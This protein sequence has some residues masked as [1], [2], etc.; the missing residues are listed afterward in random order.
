MSFKTDEENSGPQPFIR[1]EAQSKRQSTQVRAAGSGGLGCAL[2]GVV[3]VIVAVLIGVALFLPPFSLGARLFGTPYVQLNQQT[4]SAAQ[5]GL[6][7]AVDPAN[8]GSGF[9]VRLKTIKPEVFNGQAA[10][11]AEES[12]WL[13]AARASLPPTLTLLSP[14]Y[15]IDS[16]GTAS[17]VSLTVTA[18][19][20]AD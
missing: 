5:N 17:T 15:Q 8:V 13:K 3:I 9:G 20:G 7:V 19:Q 1:Q 10:P 18:P 11:N 16:Q 6:T 12:A 2:L 4:S 14:L